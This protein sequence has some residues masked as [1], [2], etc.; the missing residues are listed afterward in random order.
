MS[1]LHI[2][3][4]IPNKVYIGL[5]GGVDSMVCLDFLL[6]G[7]KEVVALHFNHGTEGA[8]LYEEFCKDECL[9]LGVPIITDRCTESIPKGRSSED[10]WR[11]KRYNFFSEF[12][13]KKIITCHHLDDA[14][15]T[16]IFSSLH[17]QSK[18]IPYERGNIIRPFILNKKLSLYAWADKNSIN[19]IEDKTNFESDYARNY[20]RNKMMKDVLHINPGI[21]KMIKKKLIKKYQNRG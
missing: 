15:E 14:V 9:K 19:F 6:R 4:K 21:Q 11:E 8:N 13:D 20:I 5:S 7:N 18:L 16:W 17:G 10:F 3:N 2:L 12:S 1:Y